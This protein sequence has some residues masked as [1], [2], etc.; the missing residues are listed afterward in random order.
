MQIYIFS[1]QIRPQHSAL[2]TPHSTFSTEPS[3][4][5]PTSLQNGVCNRHVQAKRTSVLDVSINSLACVFSVYMLRVL[6]QA[7]LQRLNVVMLRA[8]DSKSN[9]CSRAS[10]FDALIYLYHCSENKSVGL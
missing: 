1:E 7:S 10:K 3:I 9:F 8:Y 2:R 5:N 4:I 6:N